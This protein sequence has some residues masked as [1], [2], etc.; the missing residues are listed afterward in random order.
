MLVF[1]FDASFFN[2]PIHERTKCI[3]G[4]EAAENKPILVGEREGHGWNG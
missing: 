2:S 3:G 4:E 1:A